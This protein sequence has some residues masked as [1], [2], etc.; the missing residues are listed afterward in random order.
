[1]RI[2]G[3]SRSPWFGLEEGAHGRRAVL[4]VG[5]S[6]FSYYAGFISDGMKILQPCGYPSDNVF[7][8]PYQWMLFSELDDWL[9]CQED[10]SVDRVALDRQL[11]LLLQAKSGA[12]ACELTRRGSGA[13]IEW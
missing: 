12:G 8:P 11:A 2:T 1:M 4:I 6:C 7:I 10:G 13:E 9:P 5:K 3:E